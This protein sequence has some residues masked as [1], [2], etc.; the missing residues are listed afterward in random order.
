MP[1]YG[2]T[3]APHQGSGSSSTRCTATAGVWIA[4][5]LRALWSAGCDVQIIYGR[6]QPPGALRSCATGRSRRDPDA[7]VGHQGQL[8][9]IDK[10]NHSKWMTITGH[11][12]GAVVGSSSPS[13]A[14]PT[15]R[16][17][18]RRRRADA[19]TSGSPPGSP[20]L[21]T[22]AAPGSRRRP[23]S[24]RVVGTQQRA[25][26]CRSPV[27]PRTS[28]TWGT[29]VYKLHVAVRLSGAVSSGLTISSRF[30]NEGPSD[31]RPCVVRMCRTPWLWTGGQASTE[32]G[33]W[34][35]GSPRRAR[36]PRGAAPGGGDRGH[37]FVTLCGFLIT[38]LLVTE[39]RT[40]AGPLGRSS[41]GV[42]GGCSPR[43][44]GLPRVLG[45]ALGTRH[46]PYRMTV[47]EV[48]A[49]LTYVTN[50]LMAAHV[51]VSHPVGIT[52]SLSVE[53]RIYGCRPLIFLA[54]RAGRGCRWSWRGVAW[55][56][57]WCR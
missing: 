7:A 22:F 57:P 24:R 46:R 53:E 50:W 1:G 39:V 3:N 9:E 19:A 37:V 40:A 18:V 32:C 26:P 5:R 48:V 28:R 13:P 36:L 21:L 54:V 45:D 41:R 35:S 56:A 14:P 4:K 44:A 33:D 15:G 42:P 47:D 23:R 16:C 43:P 20:Y 51:D 8:G 2:G 52:W 31:T 55:R 38:S 29:G 30:V 17:G 27:C 6:Q 34:P 25:G 11:W 49:A 12:N 10:Y